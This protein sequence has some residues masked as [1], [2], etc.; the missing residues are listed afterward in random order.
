MFQHLFN[1]IFNRRRN[2]LCQSSN[3]IYL[4]SFLNFQLKVLIC[5]ILL[6]GL[7]SAYKTIQIKC[8]R[9]FDGVPPN[10]TA[11]IYLPSNVTVCPEGTYGEYPKCHKPCPVNYVGIFPDCVR[12]RCP[13]GA[14]G[15]YWPD[16]FY[17]YCPHGKIGIYPDCHDPVPWHGCEPGLLGYPPHCYKPCPPYCE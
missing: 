11:H 7:A 17:Q 14:N 13:P 8:P 1:K 2:V 16:C 10:C 5:S 3:I 4:R 12:A 15:T 6:C 9:D